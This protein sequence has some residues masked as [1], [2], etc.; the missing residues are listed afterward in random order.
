MWIGDIIKMVENARPKNEVVYTPS[1]W[2]EWTKASG[3]AVA[4]ASGLEITSDAVNASWNTL[5]VNA[6]VSTKY[7]ILL[8]VLSNSLSASGLAFPGYLVVTA[9]EIVP[10]G[11]TGYVKSVITSKAT[12]TINSFGLKPFS[13]STSGGK[14]KVRDIRM[15]ELPAGSQIESDFANLT[16][17][18]LNT[19]YPF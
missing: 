9:F 19:L 8:N 3:L 16:P 14:I 5:P 13:V 10:V 6:K 7:G 18:Q 15:F 4:D 11:V 17:D 1:T 2:A 12:I